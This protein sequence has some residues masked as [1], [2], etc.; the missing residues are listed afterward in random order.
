[1][2]LKKE[3]DQQAFTKLEAIA[4]LDELYESHGAAM[5]SRGEMKSDPRTLQRWQCRGKGTALKHPVWWE[6][7]N[8]VIKH[9]E[10]GEMAC[11]VC[12]DI[13]T[14]EVVSFDDLCAGVA[15]Q[16]KREEKSLQKSRGGARRGGYVEKYA[17]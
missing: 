5:V 7:A 17:V 8:D 11:P 12:R 14:P 4:R 15:T 9:G 13:N 10:A 16:E 3:T 2:S 6:T 1:M